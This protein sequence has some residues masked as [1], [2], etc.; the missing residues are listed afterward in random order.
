MVGKRF[1]TATDAEILQGR[2]TD[3]YFERTVAVLKKKGV[4][5]PVRAEF[6]AKKFPEE[7]GWAVLAGI[8]ECV[9]LLS[10]LPVTVRALDEGSVFYPLEPVLE[11]AGEYTSFA[12]FETAL[13]GMICQASGI[14]TRA[15]RCRRAAGVR[16]L[17]SFGTR[18]MHPA[19][20]PMIERSA[21]VGGCDGV[22]VGLSA[23]LIGV[24][25][26]GTMPHALVLVMGGTVAATKAF[27]EVI[28]R[29]VKRVS[30]IDTFDDEK[31]GALSVADALGREL[32]AVRLDTPA[33][34]RG[35]M[36]EIL[37]EVR[38]ELDLRGHRDVKLFVSGGLDDAAI[39]H[40]NPVA[41]AYGVGT[42]ISNAPV[43]DFSM[44][45]VEVDGRPLAKRGKWSGAKRVI[46]CPAC[47]RRDILP[48]S[49]ARERCA[50]GGTLSDRLQPLVEAGTLV[51]GLP[52]PNEI[53][54][55]VLRQLAALS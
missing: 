44:D 2:V 49:D 23:E 26:V 29:K 1:H 39:T 33:S 27:H 31:F 3:V 25:P 28:S 9:S 36:F 5:K 42:F 14:A 22:A 19:V 51:R 21:Y 37:R 34:R 4:R 53:R 50:C 35:E 46:R 43:I 7:Q 52:A 18:R 12:L 55:F 40:L 41:D 6:I 54:Q 11:V 13:L 10:D 16:S 24:E 48:L 15:A 17:I 8:E 32:F 38:W 45:I 20:A 47:G 30:L